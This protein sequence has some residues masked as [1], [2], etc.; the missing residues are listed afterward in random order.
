MVGCRSIGLFINNNIENDNNNNSV[1]TTTASLEWGGLSRQS[2]FQRPVRL[3]AA[4]ATTATLLS[5]ETIT[6]LD[7]RVR[8]EFA[9]RD[10]YGSALVT[11]TNITAR[12][13]PE[14][15]L[16]TV[17]NTPITASCTVADNTNDGTCALALEL[18]LAFFDPARVPQQRAYTLS[19]YYS[20]NG[21]SEIEVTTPTVTMMPDRVVDVSHG[22]MNN[23]V[24]LVAKT[25]SA[26]PGQSVTLSV[27]A[28]S[29][30]QL[31]VFT[32]VLHHDEGLTDPVLP[33]STNTSRWA[34]S[35]TR[36][37]SRTV[38]SGT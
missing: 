11:R 12:V 38:V 2:S 3:P 33:V 9:V 23:T 1:S 27:S 36:A 20:V 10:V 13:Q 7:P 24:V 28:R 14:L 16:R 37:G 17:D 4:G 15:A 8:V 26:Y 29:A 31:S 34:V 25:D 30:Y 5:R 22:V 35:T 32:V 6:S 21:G 19:V 18:P